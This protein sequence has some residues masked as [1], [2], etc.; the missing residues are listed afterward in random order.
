M[1]LFKLISV[2]FRK[3][4]VDKE[5]YASTETNIIH[6]L[7]RLKAAQKAIE[8]REKFSVRSMTGDSFLEDIDNEYDN[9]YV[10]TW[11]EYH[12]F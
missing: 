7:A 12:K 6:R 9:A 4:Q 10:E 8:K 2:I 5:N 1:G 3:R 11:N